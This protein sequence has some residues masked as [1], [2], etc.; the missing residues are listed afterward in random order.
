[1]LYTVRLA[2]TAA[3]FHVAAEDARDPLS[4][5]SPTD[6][7]RLNTY[8]AALSDGTRGYYAA[9]KLAELGP[10][11]VPAILDRLSSDDP[12]IRQWAAR[13]LTDL[14]TERATAAGAAAVD[15]LAR[16]KNE[17]ALWYLVQAVD[18]LRP[19]PRDAVP[20]LVR[21]IEHP[22]VELRRMAAAALGNVGP[23]AASAK[24]ALIRAI[25]A[26]SDNWL[27]ST[28]VQS[29]HEIG[30]DATDARAI[31]NATVSD[32][33]DGAKEIFREFVRAYPD[34]A[35]AYVQA[36]PKLLAAMPEDELVLIDLFARDDAASA[37]LRAFLGRRA[38]LPTFVRVDYAK[39][40]RIG[41]VMTVPRERNPAVCFPQRAMVAR[42]EPG[43][44]ADLTRFATH[45][46]YQLWDAEGLVMLCIDG[47]W[48]FADAVS[49]RIVI[50]P[51][52]D[53]AQNFSG[54]LA[55]VIANGKYGY[56]DKLG[57]VV[58][59]AKFDWG[60]AFAGGIA[61]VRL[62]DKY[63]LIDVNGR[64]IKEPTYKR[65]EPWGHGWRAETFDDLEGMLDANGKLISPAK[66]PQ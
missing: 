48:G 57:K 3:T 56:V 54:G 46:K 62:G 39:G 22:S 24:P 5:S 8:I 25:S 49:G 11:V 35:T 36:H 61:A 42:V 33:S 19:P 10:T 14:G 64:W 26:S 50:E 41:H 65:I 40:E 13:A 28:L 23:A 43:G 27:Q 53:R 47:K 52:F 38:D 45:P 12:V 32:D 29:L 16:E 15:A 30:I 20:V 9:M 21:L 58:V 60:Y 51:R 31:A 4:P 17:H 37:G 7:K 6:P 34:L 59:P 1:V 44:R 2:V 63:G 18:V 55:V 66:R